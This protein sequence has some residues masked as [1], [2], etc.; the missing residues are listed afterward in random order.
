MDEITLIYL[1]IKTVLHNLLCILLKFDNMVNRM[2][3]PIFFST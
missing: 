3:I 2:L 1:T